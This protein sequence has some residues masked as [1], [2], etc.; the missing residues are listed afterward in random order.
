MLR[1]LRAPFHLYKEGS[2]RSG[3]GLRGFGVWGFRVEGF[4]GPLPLI[5]RVYRTGIDI[6]RFKVFRRFP[7]T[8]VGHK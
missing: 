7:I 5:Q 2:G 4:K 3:L 8:S 1:D 6:E